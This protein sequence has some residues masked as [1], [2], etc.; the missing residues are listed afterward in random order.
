MSRIAY[1]DGWFVPMRDAAVAMEDRGYQFADGVYEVIALYQ[2]RLLDGPQHLG[3]LERSLAELNIPMPMRLTALTCVMDELLRRNKRQNGLIYIQVT[4]GVAM[5]NHVAKKH[6]KPVLTMSLNPAK[7]P[8]KHELMQGVRVITVADQRW[9]RCDVKSIALLPNVMAR[10]QAQDAGA[11]E[12]WQIN[13]QGLITEG[14]LS[15]AYI[16]RDGAIIT[17]PVNE[18]ILGGITRQTVLRLA[19]ERQIPIKEE[20]FTLAD[21]RDADEAFISGASSFV[22]PVTRIDEHTIADGKPGA[23]TQKLIQAYDEHILTQPMRRI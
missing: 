5:R 21:A 12:A 7:Y 16:V 11:K 10:M 23:L 14:S 18:R 15:N 9:T 22:L 13:A 8:S 20:A 1:V 4:R 3:R 19:M 6:M 2:N 17:H